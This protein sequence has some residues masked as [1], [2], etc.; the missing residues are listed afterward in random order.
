MALLGGVTLLMMFPTIPTMRYQGRDNGIFAYTAT[1]IAEGGVPYRDALDNKLPLVYYANAAGILLLGSNRWAI[2]LNEWVLW[3]PQRWPFL[4]WCGPWTDHAGWRCHWPFLPP[5]KPGRMASFRMA[6]LLKATRCCSRCWAY[7]WG[8]R[9]LQQPSRK[10]GAL[11]GLACGLAFL[12][13]QNTV[14]LALVFVPALLLAGHPVWRSPR[15]WAYLGSMIAGG[16]SAPLLLATYL[17]ATN[18]LDDAYQ[19]TFVFPGALHAW[20]S[21][22]ESEGEH[23]FFETLYTSLTSETF[24][25]MVM[26]MVAFAA[27]GAALA[28]VQRWRGNPDKALITLGAWAVLAFVVDLATANLTDRAFPHYYITPVAPLM[29]SLICLA[30]AARRARPTRPSLQGAVWVARVGL[31]VFMG[32][33]T[34]STLNGMREAIVEL[35]QPITGDVQERVLTTFVRQNTTPDDLVLVWGASSEINFQS[36]RHSPTNF[37]YAYPLIVPGYTTDAMLNDF[38]NDLATPA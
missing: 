13:R 37:H 7:L 34:L 1:V 24:E 26:P 25:T 15:R 20:I 31:A 30:V 11:L 32:L 29:V 5:S 21:I 35:D 3:Q 33:L 16:L 12:A 28:G 17:A 4:R 27:L 38:L 23:T 10:W 8:L 2:W 36:G 18:A 14:G 22:A 9:F 19:A 6:T